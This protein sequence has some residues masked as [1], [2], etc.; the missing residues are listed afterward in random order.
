MVNTE[1]ANL[2]EAAQEQIDE[3][4]Q[5]VGAGIPTEAV[6]PSP[7]LYK[8]TNQVESS[9]LDG[10]LTMFYQG[11]YSNTIGIMTSFNLETEQEEL[12]LVGVDLDEDGKPD[13]FPLATLITSEKTRNFLAP[14]GKG[15]FYDSQDAV[16]TAEAK[17]GMKT[18]K[19]AVVD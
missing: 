7:V 6:V 13:L 3:V 9:Q 8:F 18:F 2:F 17:E 5:V 19:E 15:G 11:V 14:D 1:Q 10:L 4:V 16:D 12:I